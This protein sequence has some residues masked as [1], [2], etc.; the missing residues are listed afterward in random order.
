MCYLEEIINAPCL[1][2]ESLKKFRLFFN[3]LTENFIAIDK[4]F[5]IDYGDFILSH[6]A[7]Q[8]LNKYSRKLLERKYSYDEFPTFE[9]LMFFS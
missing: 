5:P 4:S 3:L 9:N 6:I 8:E 1:N 2:N 7:L